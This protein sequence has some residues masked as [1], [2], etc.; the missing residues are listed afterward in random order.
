MALQ[1]RNNSIKELHKRL[2][3]DVFVK[4]IDAYSV[5]VPTLLS[6]I[7]RSNI[8]DIIQI[9]IIH[10]LIVGAIIHGWWDKCDIIYPFVGGTATAHSQN[11]KSANFTITWHGTV[12]HNENGITGDYST[13]YGDSGYT[14]NASG[15]MGL[16]D[17]HLALYRRAEG[18]PYSYYIGAS[19][20]IPATDA[21]IY[22]DEVGTY[23]AGTLCS[24]LS[25]GKDAPVP[26]G[27]LATARIADDITLRIYNDSTETIGVAGALLIPSRTLYVLGSNSNGSL[28][29]PSDATLCA[30]TA[31]AGITLAESNVMASD[32]QAF[33]TS[34]K[35]Q[36]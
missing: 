15:I 23:V 2:N 28:N 32:W 29:S 4:P 10:D 33:Q 20:A 26:L 1:V 31:G 18:Q 24:L 8:S 6:F 7:S 30:I 25:V 36:V 21:S 35:R 19:N 3:I 9:G 34:L 13:G 5:S 22:F 12:T 27:W 17:L 16:N 11:L 14:P